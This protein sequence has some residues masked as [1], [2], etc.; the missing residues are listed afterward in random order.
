[1]V[2]AENTRRYSVVALLGEGGFGKVYRARMEGPGGF[3][4]EVAVKLLHDEDFPESVRRRFRDEARILGLIRDRA[5]VSVDPPVLLSGSWAIIMEYVDGV[6]GAWLVRRRPLPPTVALEI[7]QEC[8]RALDTVYRQPGPD[9]KPLRLVHRDLKPANIQITPTGAVKILDFGIA[10]AEFGGREAKTRRHVGGTFGYIAPE[11]IEGIDGPA[12]DV[13]ALG[14]ML[15]ELVC[16]NRP[17]AAARPP[18]FSA[19]D[20]DD[21]DVHELQEPAAD[22]PEEV[23]ALAKHMRSLEPEDRPS[24]RDAEHA[25][26]ALLKEI[27]GP[28]LRTWAETHVPAA[29]PM[30][31]D[32]RV[33]T[34]LTESPSS[35]GTTS[36]AVV[37]VAEPKSNAGA[38]GVAASMVALGLAIVFGALVIGAA[39]LAVVISRV[40]SD[41][42][43]RPDVPVA[44][45]PAEPIPEPTP[46]P[47]VEPAPEPAPDP[48][49]PVPSPAPVA[50]SPAPVAPAPAPV[51]QP[52]GRVFSITLASVPMGAAVRIDGRNAGRTPLTTELPSGTYRVNMEVAGHLSERPIQV[53]RRLPVRYMW[54]A[55]EDS[56]ES[57][58]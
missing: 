2:E 13:F 23:L 41:T 39:A 14:V 18:T 6:S 50:P 12:G 57:G 46:A 47:D 30:E 16:G 29:A 10:R 54:Q 36:V 26:A 17:G 52:V 44:V 42:D 51:P 34:D 43:T 20:M 55:E 3:A 7:V 5:I 45:A 33:G 19:E 37:P 53:G 48:Q 1:M 9:E 38:V 22:V 8:A 28:T 31:P 11:R 25:C 4:K 24:A 49:P 35:S 27:Q 15:H 40:P 58:F 56:W 32:A 21:L